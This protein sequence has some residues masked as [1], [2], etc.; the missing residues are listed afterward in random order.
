MS[1]FIFQEAK[2]F[3]DNAKKLGGNYIGRTATIEEIQLLND[4]FGDKIPS[5]Y[6]KLITK[7]PLIHMEIGWQ[8]YEP[9]EDYDGIEYVDIYQPSDMIDES[10]EAYPGRPILERGFVCIGGDPA[11][12]GN[13]YFINFDAEHPA[14]FQIYHDSVDNPD[15]ILKNGKVKA[16]DSLVNFFKNGIILE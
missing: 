8:A 10:F 7:L 9:E 13:P 6:M 15:E 14:V 12:S 4:K 2:T 3:I 5:W 11:G 16:A 1:D